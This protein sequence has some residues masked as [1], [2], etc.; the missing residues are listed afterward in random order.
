M[1]DCI[2]FV[3]SFIILSIALGI[4]KVKEPIIIIDE[5]WTYPSKYDLNEKI[6]WFDKHRPKGNSYILYDLDYLYDISYAIERYR[7]AK[8]LYENI[9]YDSIFQNSFNY[10]I[11]I[12]LFIFNCK[13]LSLIEY[14]CIPIAIVLAV[15]TYNLTVKFFNR[16]W[17]DDAIVYSEYEWADEKPLSPEDFECRRDYLKCEKDRCVWRLNSR[18]DAYEMASY[19]KKYHDKTFRWASLFFT[20]AMYLFASNIIST[21]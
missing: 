10:F 4:A 15:I 14:I 12:V 20:S 18:A 13:S 5:K 16:D 11:L 2:V 19:H 3:L 9:K 8:S 17:L 6:R 1:I 21:F 7:R